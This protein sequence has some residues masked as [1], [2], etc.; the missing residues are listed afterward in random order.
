MPL[1]FT[2][3]LSLLLAILLTPPAIASTEEKAQATLVIEN[4]DVIPM[5]E[6]DDILTDR[7]V[8]IA[9]D[10]IV[11]I[12]PADEAREITDATRI[13]GAGKW[14]M[15]G[16]SDMHVHIGNSRMLRRLSGQ[17]LPA[18]GTADIQDFFTSY[19]ANGVL[20]VFDLASMAETVGQRIE[21]E[22][23]RV[24]GPHI[25]MAAMI[26]GADPILPFG[27]TRVAATP[28]DGRQVVRDAQADG[29]RFVKIYGRIDLP[30]FTAIVDEA[31]ARDMRVVGH[32]PQRGKGITASFF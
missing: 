15:P 29:Y 19:I 28:S 24:L 10:R 22:S 20:Q 21:I 1:R 26:D 6:N 31:R 18:D 3:V 2:T 25:A 4:V 12:W 16:F 27:I 23:G 8:V 17:D 30:T 11:A 7:T 13:D 32:I 5:T 9:N 14:L